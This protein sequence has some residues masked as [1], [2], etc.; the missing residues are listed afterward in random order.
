MKTQ[1][2]VHWS[3]RKYATK[4]D[5]SQLAVRVFGKA[6]AFDAYDITVVDLQS[7]QIWRNKGKS[8]RG[9]DIASDFSTIATMMHES[10]KC[11]FVML[12]PQN[13]QFRYNY[14][15]A[16]GGKDDYTSGEPLKDVLPDLTRG[17]LPLL[18]QIPISLSFGHSE[19]EIDSRVFEAD[20]SLNLAE[21][22]VD[23]K[24]LH[25]SNAKTA[26]TVVLDDRT[27]VSTLSVTGTE[28]LTCLIQSLVRDSE[29]ERWPEWL[30]EITVFDEL[31]LR[32]KRLQIAEQIHSLDE[33]LEDLDAKLFAYADDKAILCQRGEPL[34]SNARRMLAETLGI[35]NNFADEHE[36]DYR[37]ELEKS[38]LAIEIKG[39]TGA[40]KRQHVSRA[41][42][43]AQIVQDELDSSDDGRVSKAVLVFSEEIETELSERHD[44]PQ[45]QLEIASRTDVLIIPALSLLRLYEARKMGLL[46][47]TEFIGVLE[48]D[49]GLIEF[50]KCLLK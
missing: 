40:L 32:E 15:Y 39:S 4:D 6:D 28:D 21:M 48:N 22:L 13:A 12:L 17:I 46:D 3:E 16:G 38:V 2:L 27:W 35:E 10:M 49:C 41:F 23:C 29:P 14:G 31:A 36:E 44:Y 45:K 18:M 11:K 50:E 19:T 5:G 1:V 47:L 33:A 43:H 42:D 8:T 25:F 30:G 9:I 7:P 20:F 26:T 24:P 37:I 34:A